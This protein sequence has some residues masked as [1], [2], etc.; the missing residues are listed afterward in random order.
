MGRSVFCLVFSER[1]DA[2]VEAESDA[3]DP[4]STAVPHFAASIPPGLLLSPG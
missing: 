1:R 4:R 2:H 3:P